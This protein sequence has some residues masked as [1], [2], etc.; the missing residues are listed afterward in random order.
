MSYAGEAFCDYGDVRVGAFGGGGADGLVWA[1]GAGVCFAG[2]L[3]LGAWA[4]FGL[5]GYEVGGGFGGGREI[6]LGGLLHEGC[7]DGWWIGGRGFVIRTGYRLCSMVFVSVEGR[8]L[9]VW[10]RIGNGESV[11]SDFAS[12]AE[13]RMWPVHRVNR[14]LS[15]CDI[16]VELLSQ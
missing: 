8:E 10:M 15:D 3:G 14:G 2:F 9:Q 7:H 11:G 1:A 5:W 4:V 6:D 13:T 12:H 16:D